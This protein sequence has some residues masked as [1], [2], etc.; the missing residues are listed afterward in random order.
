MLDDSVPVSDLSGVSE[1]LLI[2][3]I[4]RADAYRFPGLRLRRYRR[5]GRAGPAR[6]RRGPGSPSAPRYALTARPCRSFGP[7]GF[8]PAAAVR[9][10]VM[11]EITMET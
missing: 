4:A 8:W 5:R 9:V 10:D 3:V 6:Y 1:T 11:T 2:P 7:A